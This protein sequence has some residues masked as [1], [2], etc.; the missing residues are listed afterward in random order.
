MKNMQW[1]HI[2]LFTAFLLASV[3]SYFFL[4]IPVVNWCRTLSRSSLDILE[5]ITGFGVSTAYLIVSF[6]LFVFFRFYRKRDIF[7]SQ[8]MFVFA[9]VAASGIIADI[10]KWIAG[11]YR[12]VM[13]FNEGLYGFSFFQAGYEVNSFVSGHTVTAF[14]LALALSYLY[15]KYRFLFFPAAVAI[16]ASRVL[17]SV[18]FLSDVIF[19]AYIGIATVQVLKGFFDRKGWELR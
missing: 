5:I 6:L 14:S 3:L 15:P 18:H 7:A 19:G 12:P 10:V 2:I 4:D 9:S 17:L 13:L 16:A 11:R 8:S 1:R